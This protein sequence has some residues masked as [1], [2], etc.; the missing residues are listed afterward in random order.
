[1]CGGS[2]SRPQRP[3]DQCAE[4]PLTSASRC[5]QGVGHHTR[6]RLRQHLPASRARY[7]SGVTRACTSCFVRS[8][9]RSWCRSQER[10]R[11]PAG[12]ACEHSA[13]EQCAMPGATCLT[14]RCSPS[15]CLPRTQGRPSGP[16]AATAGASGRQHSY[17]DPSLVL[18]VRARHTVTSCEARAVRAPA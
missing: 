18:V 3:G 15:S 11:H 16:A 10:S 12:T 17:V 6:G 5:W 7:R 4:P 14:A 13:A 8:C 9:V 1:M 2:L